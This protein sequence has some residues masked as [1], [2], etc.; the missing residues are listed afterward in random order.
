MTTKSKSD[1]NDLILIII[2]VAII[3]IWVIMHKP[4]MNV[5]APTPVETTVTTTTTTTVTTTTVTTCTTTVTTTTTTVTTVYDFK[6]RLID[7]G[8]FVGTYYHSEIV[9]PC[10]GGSGRTLIDCTPKLA[11]IKGSVACRRVQEDYGYDI[12]GRTRVWLEFTKYPNMTGW[13]F[14]DDACRDY[15]V[16]DVYF[17]EYSDCPWEHDGKTEVHLWLEP[18]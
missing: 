17:I 5:Y 15:D 12:N 10:K 18:S 16:V 14:L 2:L 8:Y 11:E 13:Y 9:N 3:S 6:E 1:V 7:Y 4:I